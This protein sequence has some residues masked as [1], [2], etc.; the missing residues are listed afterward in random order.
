MRG[1]ALLEVV[2]GV[3]LLALGIIFIAAI[4]PTSIY[5]I[6][7]A[8]D[9]QAATAYANELLD[10]AR[11]S[12]P[13]A[14]ESEVTLTFNQTDFKLRR[15]VVKVDESLTDVVVTVRWRDDMPELRLATRV[16]GQPAAP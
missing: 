8:E 6:K 15:L 7:R 5:S 11:R 14:G 9:I 2:I 4:L 16:H 1:I 3:A 12:L 13:R 10:E